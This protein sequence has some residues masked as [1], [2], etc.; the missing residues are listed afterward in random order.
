M[1][2]L[3]PIL[4]FLITASIMLVVRIVWSQFLY[5]WLIAVT[6]AML[7]WIGMLVISLQIPLR[8]TLYQ[9]GPVSL[10][11]G[12]PTLV[13]DRFSWPFAIAL[14]TLALAVILTDAA[15][16]AEADWSSWTATL[17]LAALG[18][19]VVQADNPLTL[20][21][22]WTALDLVE[23]LILLAQVNQSQIRER[24]VIAFSSRLFGSLLMVA[25]AM[26]ASSAGE[27]LTFESIPTQSSFFFIL[28]AGLRLGV[29]PLHVPFF[30]ELPIRRGLGT[31]TRLVSMAAGLVLL[32]RTADG[33]AESLKAPYFDPLLALAALAGLYGGLAWFLAEDELEGRQAWILGTASLSL[34]AALKAQP[35]ACLAW[36]LGALMSGGLLFLTSV[37]DRRLVWISGLGFLGFSALPYSP[38]WTGALS[39]TSAFHPL[40]VTFIFIQALLL[41]GYARHALQPG[42]SLA[43]VERWVWLG[44][45]FGLLLLPG[46]QFVVGWQAQPVSEDLSMA[47]WLVGPIALMVT[48]LIM[49]LG[50]HFWN[51]TLRIISVLQKILSLNWFYRLLWIIYRNLGRLSEF[52]T[53]VLE[54]EGGVLWALLVLVLLLSVL[55]SNNGGG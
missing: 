3:I 30:Q 12:S 50:Y 9:W 17:I 10:L 18:L 20:L 37:H 23:L 24:V 15:R 47:T 6:G 44:Y 19:L 26:V 8:I 39:F 25:G 1:L 41:A 54:G 28:A 4:L 55:A 27:N 43:G 29:L 42:P 45:P 11:D 32:V 38:T 16:A 13:L 35:T 5:H 53:S 22:G 7:A 51:R 2:L 33:L 14:T 49:Y 48:A 21:L 34:L 31:I 46:I 52:F 36:G 40:L